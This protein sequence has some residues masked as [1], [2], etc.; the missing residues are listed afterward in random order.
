MA[1][2]LEELRLA[3]RALGRT[4]WASITPRLEWLARWLSKRLP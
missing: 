2:Q 3:V 1:E 4:L